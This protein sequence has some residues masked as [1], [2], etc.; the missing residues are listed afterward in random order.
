MEWKNTR[1]LRT[2]ARIADTTYRGGARSLALANKEIQGREW[3]HV[4]QS[5]RNLGRPRPI[6]ATRIDREGYDRIYR[7][8]RPQ[9]GR[10]KT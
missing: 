2:T 6:K 5:W 9:T 1:G 4:G 3:R 10:S 8:K 7:V